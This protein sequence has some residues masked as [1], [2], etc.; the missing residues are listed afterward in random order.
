MITRSKAR[1]IQQAQNENKS[2]R[3]TPT[4][5]PLQQPSQRI[6]RNVQPAHRPDQVLASSHDQTQLQHADIEVAP[7][8]AIN[9]MVAEQ[10]QASLARATIEPRPVDGTLFGEEAFEHMATVRA[11][12]HL[13]QTSCK[14]AW[15]YFRIAT[16]ACQASVVVQQTIML[17]SPNT[18][19]K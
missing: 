9:Q 18:M 19:T 6:D 17:I 5:P 3:A 15:I 11:R 14:I 16:M 13:V 10:N 2:Q 4:Q 8:A 12:L 1:A 7:L